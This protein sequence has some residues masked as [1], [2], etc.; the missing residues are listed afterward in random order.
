MTTTK[1]APTA[2]VPVVPVE[3]PASKELVAL[4]DELTVLTNIFAAIGDIGIRAKDHAK[5]G[6]LLDYINAK[7]IVSELAVKEQM[8]KEGKMV[9]A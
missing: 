7:L 4:R 8:E 6:E 3:P 9:A 1:E 2:E 5:A